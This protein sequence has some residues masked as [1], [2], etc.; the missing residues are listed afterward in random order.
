[1]E[2]LSLTPQIASRT[3][4]KMLAATTAP[5]IDPKKR[6][7]LDPR[8]RQFAKA[9]YVEQDYEHR[10][11]FYTIPPTGDVSLEQFEEWGI[12]RLKILAELE[13]CQFRNKTPAET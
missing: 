2:F 4:S 6:A 7:V 1:M 13:A 9:Q 10:M 5:R 3:N 8:K 12:A 11:N